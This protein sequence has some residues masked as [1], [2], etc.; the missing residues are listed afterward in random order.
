MND[1]IDV[2]VSNLY[3]VA[4]G[5]ALFVIAYASNILFGLWYNIKV[6][7]QKFD[8]NRLLW[9]LVKILAFGTATSLLVIGITL[10]PIFADFVGFAIPEEYSEVFQDLAVIAV[11]IIS[12][13]K[14]LIEAYGKFK[15]ILGINIAES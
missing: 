1:V 7:N 10:V 5:C 2:V 3:H 6:L 15:A 4:L 11:F 8:I 12:S 14:Y 13:C 9:S